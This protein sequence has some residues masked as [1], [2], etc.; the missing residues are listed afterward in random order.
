MNIIKLE[1]NNLNQVIRRTI[2]ILKKRGLVIFPSDT[3]YGL[4]VDATNEKAVEKLIE[5]KER[6]KGKPISIFVTNVRTIVTLCKV[7][8]RQ[9]NILNK[10][11]P[12]PFTAVL[13]YKSNKK[14][15]INKLL[16]S[17]KNTLGVRVPDFEHINKLIQL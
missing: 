8:L 12:G 7:D 1:K 13:D 10:I 17:E 14:F 2:K 15:N 16:L 3:V 4:L 5:F 9:K 6:P 11:L